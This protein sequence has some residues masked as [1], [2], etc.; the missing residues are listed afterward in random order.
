MLFCEEQKFPI[1]FRGRKI[2]ISDKVANAHFYMCNLP[3][4]E[5]K[6]GMH[7]GFYLKG[8]ENNL[9]E[10]LNAISDEELTKIVEEG[11]KN[12][13]IDLLGEKSWN[14]IKG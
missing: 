14:S 2:I 8:Q 10:K 12:E 11:I 9:D 7:V 1:E 13:F 3:V 6:I 4:N 5:T